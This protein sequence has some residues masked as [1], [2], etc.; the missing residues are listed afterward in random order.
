MTVRIERVFE[1]PAPPERVWSFISDPANRARAIS[2]VDEYAVEGEDGRSVTW[3]V[4]LPIPFVSKTVTVETRDQTR[5]PPQFVE[6]TGRSRIMDVTG[7]HELTAHDDGCLLSN[8]F[9][10]E[11]RVPGV[12]RFFERNFD[13]EMENLKREAVRDL[14]ADVG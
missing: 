13:A 1:L 4:R 8:R 7:S 9:V 12:E 10:V 6:F 3:E 11:G 14:Q 2:V 5:E